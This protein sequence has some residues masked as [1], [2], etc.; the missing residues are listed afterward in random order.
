MTG[1]KLFKILERIG[2]DA[3]LYG[4]TVYANGGGELTIAM[5]QPHQEMHRWLLN[6]GFIL[7]DCDY[8]YRPR[9]DR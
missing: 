9:R 6:K 1:A 2:Q 4:V 5:Q 3:S 8:V 7:N